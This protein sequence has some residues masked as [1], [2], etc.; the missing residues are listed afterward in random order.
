MKK[1]LTAAAALL[2][3]A[4]LTVTCAL[5]FTP[6]DGAVETVENAAVAAAP[7]FTDDAALLEGYLYRANG[8]A[9]PQAVEQELT[10]DSASAPA[11]NAVAM[12]AVT[13][14]IYDAVV[15]YIKEIAA[16]NAATSVVRLDDPG[17]TTSQLADLD[18]NNL[19]RNLLVNMPYELYWFD[20]TKGVSSG[21]SYDGAGRVSFL[22]LTFKVS[23]DYA[24]VEGSNYHSDRPDTAKTGAATRAA[25][26]AASV[27]ASNAAKSN[28]DKLTAYLNYI[29]AAVSYNSDAAYTSGYP[30]GDPWQL[31]YVF[32]GDPNT[33]VV[34][35]GYSKAFKY[36]CDL[37][38]Q[39][40]S[41]AV[42]CYLP[43]GTMNG[44]GH[45]WNIVSIGGANYLAD[46]TNCDAGTIGSPDKLFLCG[47]SGS[48]S[49]GY[50]V[51]IP[52]QRAVAYAYDA[53]TKSIYDTELELSAEAYTPATY[54]MEYL[55]RLARHIAR[56]ESMADAADLSKADVN[57]DGVV[58]AADL[59]ALANLLA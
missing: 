5:A 3:A 31:I 1:K 53:G 23:Q 58:S 51:S 30:Y 46:V 40:A 12:N 42:R 8:L 17:I 57:G 33:N 15:P 44:G 49:G 38:W 50:S 26:E 16:G 36:L 28:Y 39:G 25:A 41:P 27:V 43:T 52:G 14:K 37:T 32:D 45:M 20:K 7:G 59:T 4:A 55:R 18:I 9:V 56:I 13:Q 22:A 24:V 11:L 2:L 34:C 35:E 6:A 10:G 29:K 19:L 47:A 21:Y 54:D 48:V